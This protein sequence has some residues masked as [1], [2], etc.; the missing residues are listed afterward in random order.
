MAYTGQVSARQRAIS[1]GGALIAV[2][3]IGIGLASGLDL[4]VVRKASDAITAIAIPA[5][6]PPPREQV[7]PA[8]ASSQRASGKASA[9][10][11]HAKAAPVFAPK[12]E[13]PPIVPPVAA[14][15]RPGA[16]N[17]ASAGATPTPGS[18][19]GAGGRGDGT[20]SGG[21]GSGTG[22]GTKAVWRSGT[23]H[24][25]DYPREASRAKAGGEVEVRFTIEASGRVS[26][27]RVTRP[28]G[29]ASLDQTTCRL[30]EDR[31]RFKPATNSAG[32]PV[33]SQYGWRQSWWLERRN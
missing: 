17:D 20:G 5:P 26:G 16:G 22:G 24:D 7:T 1:G 12:T 23:I 11:K 25:R 31:F 8:K 13:L 33:A 9:A 14:A 27:C 2:L 21:S 6:P 3:A 32:E 28:S 18:G 30:I 19:S 4:E 15:P 10:N 29:D